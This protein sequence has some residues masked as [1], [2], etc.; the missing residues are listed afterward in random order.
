MIR[1]HARRAFARCACRRCSRWARGSQRRRSPRTPRRPTA[2]EALGR[3]RSGVRARQGGRALGEAHHRTQR[4]HARDRLHPGASL[5]Q[6][7]PER[8]FAA[9]RDGHG[10]S[11][12]RLDA[13]LV[14]AGRRARRRR[15]AVARA[16]AEGTRGAR[17]R[18]RCRTGCS[19]RSTRAGAIPLALAPLGHRA[20]A[21][22][23]NAVR[24]PGRPART[25]SCGS[26]RRR[27]SSTSMP[28]LGALPQAMPFADA[29]AA[30]PRRSARRAG[31][32]GRRR[33]P[34]RG[35][36]RSGCAT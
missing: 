21:T 4:R 14:G 30:F 3:R 7:D 28:A 10:G 29:Q 2:L 26:R 16:G 31:R 36:T 1:Q 25:A 22:R 23:A 33:S 18:R 5:A 8:E 9:L 6:R 17:D 20:L 34:R 15:P 24:T 19:R 13:P 12:R 32:T 27:T 11:R 35:S